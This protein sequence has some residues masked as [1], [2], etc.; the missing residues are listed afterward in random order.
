LH[1]HI[2]ILIN[3]KSTIFISF[4]IQSVIFFW[5]VLSLT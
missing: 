4:F 2:I 3:I 5:L 1:W